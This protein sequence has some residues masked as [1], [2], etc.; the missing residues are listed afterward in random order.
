MSKN[1]AQIFLQRFADFLDRHRNDF[2]LSRIQVVQFG[3]PSD[4]IDCINLID[5]Q[6]TLRHRIF[7]DDLETILWTTFNGCA[8][9][10]EIFQDS[11]ELNKDE[12]KSELK[13]DLKLLFWV[14]T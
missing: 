13:D 9:E 5:T 1:I 6:G 8:G 4:Y 7:A 12:G 2:K 3:H 10:Q 14:L 11:Y